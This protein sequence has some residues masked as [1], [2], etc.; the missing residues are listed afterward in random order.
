MA[1]QEVIQGM[2]GLF[3]E[4]WRKGTQPN[5]EIKNAWI[6]GLKKYH[7]SQILDASD[8]L[9][10]N[11]QRMPTIADLVEQIKGLSPQSSESNFLRRGEEEDYSGA[12]EAFTICS[13]CGKR[14][15]CRK[16]FPRHPEYECEDCYTGLSFRQRKQRYKD[17]MVKM[18]WA[19]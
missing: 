3:Y 1:T 14:R 15:H 16:E 11:F 7:D 10:A 13:K 9:M 4:L 19:A 18:G 8:I 5:D 17:L 6:R 12:M 2:V